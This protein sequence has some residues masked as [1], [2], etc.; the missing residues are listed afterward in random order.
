MDL[1]ERIY[2]IALALEIEI[3]TPQEVREALML[4]LRVISQGRD[5]D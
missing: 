3:A 1:L 5:N 2:K 4:R